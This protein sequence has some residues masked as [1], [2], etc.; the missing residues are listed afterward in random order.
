MTGQR[1]A[2][3]QEYV[4]YIQRVGPGQTGKLEPG[5]DETTQAIRP[6]LTAAAGTLGKA[7]VSRRSANAIYFWP[8]EDRRRDRPRKDPVG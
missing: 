7:L 4:G 5:E 3:L 1:A 6:R 8:P 2:L